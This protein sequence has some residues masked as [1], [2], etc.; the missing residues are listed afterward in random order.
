[1]QHHGQ[2]IGR[3]DLGDVGVDEPAARMIAL[4]DFERELDVLGREV[5]AVVPFDAGP[6]VERD[7]QTVR[8]DVPR[9]RELRL[10]LALAVIF[11]QPFEDLRGDEGGGEAGID[12]GV[13]PRSCRA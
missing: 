7:G 11:D 8:A 3:V 10:R 13:W 5:D 6:Q 9:L 4:P 1:M 2:R 12:G